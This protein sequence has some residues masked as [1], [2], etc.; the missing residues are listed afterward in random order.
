MDKI[1]GSNY[2]RLNR[3]FNIAQ[4]EY[5]ERPAPAYARSVKPI[6]DN[7]TRKKKGESLLT[8]KVSKKKAKTADFSDSELS[9]SFDDEALKK[10][11]CDD[12]VRIFSLVF[13]SSGLTPPMLT[14]LDNYF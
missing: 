6:I 12:E 11:S 14:V 8:K 1:F 9:K 5:G 2:K 3:V 7:V 13:Y 4:I 10:M